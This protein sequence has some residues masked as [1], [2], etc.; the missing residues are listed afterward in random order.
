[1]GG[2][3]K[4]LNRINADCDERISQINSEADIKCSQIMADAQKQAQQLSDDITKKAAAKVLQIKSAAKSRA[5]LETRNALLKK[6]REEID[7][8]YKAVLAKMTSLADNEYF[9]IIYALA[10]KL[11]GKEGV[12]MLNAKDLQRLPKD[13]ISRLEQSGVKAQLSSTPANISGGFILK[14]G[15]IEENMDFA[16][17]LADKR[18]LIEDLIN[19]ELFIS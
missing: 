10:K 3:D 14:C 6:R 8:T 18:D 19:H 7:I 1:M 15:D 17:I 4:I 5:E 9:D 11:C 12:V 2:G 16:A 13:F